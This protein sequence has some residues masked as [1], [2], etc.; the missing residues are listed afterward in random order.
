VFTCEQT[1]QNFTPKQTHFKKKKSPNITKK[2]DRRKIYREERNCERNWKSQ[3]CVHARN[4]LFIPFLHLQLVGKQKRVSEEFFEQKDSLFDMC[5]I[6]WIIKISLIGNTI[7]AKPPY[8]RL[9][10]ILFL[11]CYQHKKFSRFLTIAKINSGLHIKN[12]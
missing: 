2:S 7:L 5:K 12:S 1:E 11:E 8:A 4:I 10:N 6:I 9:I 3:S